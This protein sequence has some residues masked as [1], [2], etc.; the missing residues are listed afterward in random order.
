M[1]SFDIYVCAVHHIIALHVGQSH[2][3]SHEHCISKE[4][5]SLLDKSNSWKNVKHQQHRTMFLGSH[6][7]VDGYRPCSRPHSRSSLSGESH[8]QKIPATFAQPHLRHSSSYITP[9]YLIFSNSIQVLT[10][11]LNTSIQTYESNLTNFNSTCRSPCHPRAKSQ[12]APPQR[13]A[14]SEIHQ[15]RA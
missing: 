14:M 8:P 1:V 12:P 4:S 3:C 11:H 9:A 7:A 6:A 5:M 10:F 15:R 2:S 13:Q